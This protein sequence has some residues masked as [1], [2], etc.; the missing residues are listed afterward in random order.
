[1]KN[2]MD[3]ATSVEPRK[4][5]LRKPNYTR[6]MSTGIKENAEIAIKLISHVFSSNETTEVHDMDGM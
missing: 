4:I 2:F 3:C 1:M 6:R 5:R